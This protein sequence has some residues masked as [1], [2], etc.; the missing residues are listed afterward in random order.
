VNA[1][2]ARRKVVLIVKIKGRTAAVP[3]VAAAAMVEVVVF[4]KLEMQMLKSIMRVVKQLEERLE[5]DQRGVAV[6]VAVVMHLGERGLF[7][8]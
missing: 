8:A 2:D 1:D 7:S 6:I 4:L 3:V 5:N